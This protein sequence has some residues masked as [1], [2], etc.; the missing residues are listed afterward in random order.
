[1]QSSSIMHSSNSYDS[2]GYARLLNKLRMPP[3]RY[4][5]TAIMISTTSTNRPLFGI[6]LMLAAMAILPFLDVVAKFL[7]QQGV[8]VLQIVWARVFFGTLITLPF[9]LKLAGPKGL[10]PNMPVVHG[11]RAAFLMAATGCFFWSL[12]Y[13]SI[14]GTLSIFFV[15]P[16]IVTMLSPLVLGEKVGMRRWAA[17]VTGF[18]GTLIIIRPGFQE[19]NPGVFLALAAGFSLAIYMLL[20]ARISGS[21]PAMV[22][23]YYTSL[24]GTVLLSGYVLYDWQPVTLPQWGLFVLLAAIANGGHYLIVRAYDYSEAS[25]LAPLAYTEMIMATAAGWWFF[26]EFPDAWTFAGVGILIACAIYIS[27]REPALN[28]EPIRDFEQP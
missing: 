3:W 15:Q 26:G 14:A 24:M 17:V 20:T 6:G 9:A 4:S 28:I 22:T 12:H 18:V 10:L 11:I 5:C 16:L 27:I 19:I 1:M 21:A 8:P 2:K 13:L 7:G 25:L 23:T